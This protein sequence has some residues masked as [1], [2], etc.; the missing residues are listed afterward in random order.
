MQALKKL[1]PTLPIEF[2][3][4]ATGTG[5]KIEIVLGADVQKYFDFA[6]PVNY[7]L[8]DISPKEETT[9][10]GSAQAT[11]EETPASPQDT[12]DTTNVNTSSQEANTETPKPA[13]EAPVTPPSSTSGE[14]QAARASLINS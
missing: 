13:D 6:K 7:Y 9:T 5:V 11:T 1:E 4:A 10:S 2:L 8:N 12:P 14:A 3:P